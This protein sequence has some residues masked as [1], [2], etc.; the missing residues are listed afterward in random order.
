M[1]PAALLS[2]QRSGVMP[3]TVT[4][5]SVVVVGATEPPVA[6]VAVVVAGA[7]VGALGVAVLSLPHA[8]RRARASTPATA[9][10][11]RRGRFVM[12]PPGSG[13]TSWTASALRAV[14]AQHDPLQHADESG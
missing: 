11:R 14:P 1:P 3:L 13:A 6:V 10:A 8:A 2:A 12:G 4:P 5:G 7:A 9:G